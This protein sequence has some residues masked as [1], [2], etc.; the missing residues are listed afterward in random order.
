MNELKS[1]AK[2]L[3]A[4][5]VIALIVYYV[6]NHRTETQQQNTEQ[7]TSQQN[8]EPQ[9]ATGPPAAH[10]RILSANCLKETIGHGGGSW[11]N[12]N[13]EIKN[14]SDVK[15]DSLNIVASFRARD[16]T[17]ISS[18]FAFPAYDPLLPRQASPFTISNTG[19]PEIY[20]AELGVDFFPTSDN[21]GQPLNLSGVKTVKCA[22]KKE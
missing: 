6:M 22:N 8:T 2:L 5:A 9:T 18:T 3:W 13:G 11:V 21:R 7:Q 14:L 19:N 17:L 12:I 10:L 4:A 20:S 1:V 16:G 15:L